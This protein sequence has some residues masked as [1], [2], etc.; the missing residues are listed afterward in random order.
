[1]VTCGALATAATLAP[2]LWMLVRSLYGAGA[3]PFA[4]LIWCVAFAAPVGAAWTWFYCRDPRRMLIAT[5][6]GAVFGII[7]IDS[8]GLVLVTTGL[9]TILAWLFMADRT[10][11]L[12]ALGFIHGFLG[13]TFG[14]L[15]KG[16]AAGALHVDYR[17]GP[18]NVIA[19][20]P[21][22]LIVPL[23][24][25]AGLLVLTW[26]CWRR[27]PAAPLASAATSCSRY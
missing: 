21:Q 18:W 24:C 22:V 12:T 23:L 15:F 1:M 8:Y 6:S 26:W 3:A 7:H 9:G 16:D 4:M 13:S 5:L 19:F 25:L 14:K 2:G 20:I 17:V 10:R 11:N 27:L